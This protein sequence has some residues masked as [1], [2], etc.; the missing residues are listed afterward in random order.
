MCKKILFN[1]GKLKFVRS[2]LVYSVEYMI[3]TTVE[4]ATR[5]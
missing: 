2:N 5:Q 3:G 4:L 1:T